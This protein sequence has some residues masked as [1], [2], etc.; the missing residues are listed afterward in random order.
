MSG[1]LVTDWLQAKGGAENVFEALTQAFPDAD[2]LCLW[3]DSDGR[4]EGV[5]ETVLAETP[6]RRHKAAAL[7]VMPSVWRNLAWSDAEWILCASHLFA[8]HARFAGPARHAPKLVYAHTPAR[9]LWAPELDPRGSGAVAR[10]GAAVLKPIDRHRASEA[11]AIAA[12]SRFVADRI[13]ESWNREAVVIHPPV[14]VY[15]FAGPL[16]LL[17]AADRAVVKKLPRDYLLGVSRFVSY[18]RLERVID[19]GAATGMPVVLAGGGPD[20]G[21]LRRYARARSVEVTFVL[22]PSKDLLAWLYRRAWALVFPS[23]EDFGIVPIEAMASGTPVI[24]GAV[25]G[26]S[27][28]VVD[29]V[30]GVIVRDWTRE[31][32]IDAVARVGMISPAASMA[33][34]LDFDESVFLNAIRSWIGVTVGIAVAA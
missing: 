20:E 1:V 3:N 23:V 13:R 30:S 33:R 19:A 28:S 21:E 2:R 16:P 29:G 26:Q 31:G 15:R 11:V 24:T 12:N 32:L 7:P 5:A 6:L 14:D 25:G 4:F 17:Q 34:A 9:Y 18:K 10:A 27:E 22:L 8:H